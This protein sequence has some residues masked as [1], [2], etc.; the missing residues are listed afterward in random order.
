MF[1]LRCDET[2]D[3]SLD[4]AGAQGEKDP[5]DR[6][7]HLIDPETFG[8]DRAGE[9][10]P[11]TRERRPAAVRR[12]VPVMSG[13]GL[14]EEGMAAPKWQKDSVIYMWEQGNDMNP[15]YRRRMTDM[16]TEIITNSLIL[17]DLLCISEKT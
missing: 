14:W 15:V 17:S 9:K 16:K 12:I 13:W 1:R 2:G 11:R 3:R 6:K 8:A 7:D 5:V 10:K 4:R